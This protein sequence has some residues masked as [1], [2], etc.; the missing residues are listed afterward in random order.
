MESLLF[1]VNFPEG[2]ETQMENRGL[3]R[4]WV[5]ILLTALT[6]A[7]MVM[8]FLFSMET[9]EESDETSG[10]LARFV[11]SIVWPDFGDYPA[12]EQQ[13]MFDGAQFAVRKSAH[14]SEYMLLGLLMRLCL[15][16]WF[17]KHRWL[18]P[19]AWGLST[20]YAASDEFHQ[21]LIDG[22]SGQWTDVF[23][24]SAGVLT[25]VLVIALVLR[26]VRKRN[27]LEETEETCP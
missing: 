11:I 26:L 17:G 19:A 12:E 6:L 20:L 18:S 22:R 1:F 4:N 21:L 9:A 15:E 8:I 2:K 13:A 27:R 23:I 3:Q 14:F 25:G 16:S 7:V 10:T 5:R 24:D